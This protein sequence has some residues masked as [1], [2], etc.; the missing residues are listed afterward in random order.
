MPN[1]IHYLIYYPKLKSIQTIYRSMQQF[2]FIF[3][4]FY[5][6]FFLR[7]LS[8]NTHTHGKMRESFLKKLAVVYIQNGLTIGYIVQ[9]LNLF[10]SLIFQCEINPL[11]F[12]L[13]I[14]SINTH[15]GRGEKVFIK[16][17]TVMYIQKG[18]TLG[19]T[20]QTLNLFNSH[21]F[22]NVGLTNC[23]FF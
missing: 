5:F 11:F 3:F 22:S 15:T 18:L 9:V 12:L 7:I 8:I 14:L 2:S 21:S 17:I 23:F 6:F 19:N 1:F 10:N 13:R 20:A 4:F 16:K